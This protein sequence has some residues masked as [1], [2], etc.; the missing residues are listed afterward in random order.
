MNQVM[1]LIADGQ[2]EDRLRAARAVR[3]RPVKR[4]RAQEQPAWMRGLTIRPATPDDRRALRRL[5]VLDSAEVPAG[6]VVLAEV[7]GELHAALSL[8]DGAIVADPF[9][10][11]AAIVR[12]LIAWAEQAVADRKA[13]WPRFAI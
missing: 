8:T 13:R 3:D 7:A 6:P 5:A 1:K 4:D 11:T 9:R 2:V 10:P 12:L